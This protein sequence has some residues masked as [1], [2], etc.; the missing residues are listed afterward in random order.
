MGPVII[1]ENGGSEIR[2]Q[3]IINS[4][5]QSGINQI[6]VY[7]VI[8]SD[9]IINSVNVISPALV[10]LSTALKNL[11]GTEAERLTVINAGI[12]VSPDEIAA[13]SNNLQNI[14]TG[15]CVACGDSQFGRLDISELS[16]EN[17]VGAIV[18]DNINPAGI[19]STPFSILEG[20][21]HNELIKPESLSIYCAVSA[22][23]NG[24]EITMLPSS[25]SDFEPIAPKRILSAS[26]MA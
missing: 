17:L 12:D 3:N 14:S 4:L 1:I 21:P 7:G 5:S 2:L 15:F 19:I 20:L 10:S 24:E 13:I 22:L 16:A 9:T 8:S 6:S 23:A 26:E 25:S 18:E 11:K